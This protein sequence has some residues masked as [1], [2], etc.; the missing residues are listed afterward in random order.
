[1]LLLCSALLLLHDLPSAEG[2]TSCFANNSELRSAVLLYAANS[3]NGTNTTLTYGV[4]LPRSSVVSVFATFAL[5]SLTPPYS[6]PF[7]SC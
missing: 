4:R 1:V 6:S 3:T 5:V 7:L 2:A